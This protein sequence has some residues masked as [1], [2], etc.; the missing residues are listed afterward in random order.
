MA[1]I[2]LY[3]VLISEDSPPQVT[4][5]RDL[6]TLQ[7]A[8]TQADNPSTVGLVH[9]GF[10]RPKIQNVS[11]LLKH[12]GQV[13]VSVA[14]KWALPNEYQSSVAVV[15]EL[16]L[17]SQVVPLHQ[18]IKGLGFDSPEPNAG[19]Q[20]SPVT[21]DRGQHT[22]AEAALIVL[23]DAERPLNKEEIFARIIEQDL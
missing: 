22:I 6:L 20:S 4:V 8:W 19:F 23:N 21:V 13:L 15:A 14:A 5:H 1:A 7:T 2:K 3:F 9:I 12:K 17:S 16:S 11:D 10:I 18:L